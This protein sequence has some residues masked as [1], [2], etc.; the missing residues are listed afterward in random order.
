MQTRGLRPPASTGLYAL[1]HESAAARH[2]PKKG[3]NP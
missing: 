3:S 2:L 1:L